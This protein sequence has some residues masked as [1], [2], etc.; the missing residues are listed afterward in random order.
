MNKMFYIVSESISQDPGLISKA[1]SKSLD[2]IRYVA[3]ATGL[4]DIYLVKRISNISY[5]VQSMAQTAD[6]D[7]SSSVENQISDYVYDQLKIL[8]RD[9]KSR[10][11]ITSMIPVFVTAVIFQIVF[12]GVLAIIS[13]TSLIILDT[14]KPSALKTVSDELV[15]LSA[16]CRTMLFLF[17]SSFLMLFKNQ[18]SGELN[19][20][21]MNFYSNRGQ[22]ER[23]IVITSLV[24]GTFNGAKRF[25]D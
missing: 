25:L 13:G 11:F 7:N 10:G 9:I 16:I 21:I 5:T 19:K 15:V 14:V 1:I 20:D 12:I 2:T 6:S 8:S 3:K 17:G 4:S 23:G 18:K 22:P 24:N